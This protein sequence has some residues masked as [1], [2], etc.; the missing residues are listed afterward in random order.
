MAGINWNLGPPPASMHDRPLLLIASPVGRLFDAAED[1]RPS[2]Y[3]GHYGHAKDG[4][5]PARVWGMSASEPRPELN[6]YYW[7]E[8]DLPV[9]VK[10]RT[11]TESDWMG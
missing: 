9:G 2:L 6:V 8:I 1:N 7:A 4:F 5:V 3:I 11:L 10:T